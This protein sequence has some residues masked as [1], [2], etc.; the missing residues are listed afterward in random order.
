MRRE[1][2]NK[3][4]L[5]TA[6]ILI[7]VVGLPLQAAQQD[8]R[9][10]A[11]LD[12][13]VELIKT[14]HDQEAESILQSVLKKSPTQPAA[15]NLLG[16]I[17]AKQ[18]RLKEAEPFFVQSSQADPQYVSPLM[19]LA[20]LYALTNETQK[21]F[22]VL[23]RVLVIEPN[24]QEGIER[25]SRLSLSAGRV[26]EGI[27]IL[28][29]ARKRGLLTEPLLVLL[30]D[31]YVRQN[32]ISK[33]DDCYN[34]ALSTQPEDT[35]AVLGLAQSAIKTG[36]AD[37]ALEYLKRT[38]R[39]VATTPDTLYKFAMVAYGLGLYEE[40]N[41]TL[42]SAI[43]IKPDDADYYFAL[44]NTWIKKPDLVEAEDAFR[45][46]N[47]LRPGDA[48]FELNLGYTL[49]EQKKFDEAREWLEKSRKTSPRVPEVNF[50]LG[51]LAADTGDLPGAID[52]F[53][54][55]IALAPS[56]AYAHTELGEAYLKLKDYGS[57]Q[58]EFEESI[59]ID[60]NDSR[61]HYDLAI[62]FARLRD[63]KRSQEQLDITEK[64]KAADKAKRQEA[65]MPVGG[66]ETGPR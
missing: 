12:Q 10:G 1:F 44:G 34:A 9:Q 56:Y 66:G 60:P 19:N 42:L 27:R 57:A 50:Y 59:R 35:D 58:K 15:L 32:D 4:G 63:Q 62:L 23:T 61:A 3:F 2:V 31:A 6:I 25:L 43:K 16:T 7:L 64:I 28:E 46:A 13:A 26:E 53:K 29:G 17:R 52:L 11:Q 45:H 51:Q 5:T 8:L 21:A 33:A 48:V 49:L 41:R 18:G 39:M 40:S 30:G 14:N 38:R 47:Q 22:T 37:K 36:N 20:Y 65:N 55:A 24:N 54:K